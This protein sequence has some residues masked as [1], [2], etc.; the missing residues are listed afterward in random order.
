MLEKI[1]SVANDALYSYV[2]IILLVLG[3][4]Y[5]TLRSKGVQFSMLREQLRVVGEKP[6][7][8]KGISS[9][10][11]LMVSTASRV[12]TGNIIG[13]S[14]ALCI[15]GFG[16]VFWMW[17]NSPLIRC[18]FWRPC[19]NGPELPKTDGAFCAFSDLKI[20]CKT[21]PPALRRGAP[22]L[23]RQLFPERY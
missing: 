18:S 17:V 12:G 21:E 19:W 20:L 10:G 8:G 3:G 23:S 4:L 15:G 11:A 2:L 1:I 9:F 6:A 13:V 5:F 7:D 16:S 14:T 22:F